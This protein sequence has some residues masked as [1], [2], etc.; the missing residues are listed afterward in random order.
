MALLSLKC[1]NCAGDIQ[2]DDSRE[3]GFCM[4]CGSRVLITKDVNNIH[5]ES[6]FEKQ[7]QN[8][9]ALAKA[10]M[11]SG[12]EAEAHR[13]V[14]QIIGLNGADADIWYADFILTLKEYDYPFKSCPE[15]ARTS[16][17]NFSSI[18][19][20]RSSMDSLYY[21]ELANNK[22]VDSYRR[23]AYMAKYGIGI[24][25]SLEKSAEWRLKAARLGDVESKREVAKMCLSGKG[26]SK[27]DVEAA[28]WFREA[29]M[30]G[31]PESQHA[32]AVMYMDGTGVTASEAESLKWHQKAAQNGNLDSA[33]V[34]D[35][36]SVFN[37]SMSKN[38]SGICI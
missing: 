8:L 3:F 7:I 21:R 26:L 15:S 36:G 38:Y 6:S 20:S 23:L 13:V 18:A 2:L 33:M 14:K 4:Y 35:I 17:E 27:S 11:A 9:K 32:I 16:Y 22:D 1:P 30:A 34:C 37:Y 29:A 24:A 31:D 12:K 5:V 10:H 19:K 25:A 28:R